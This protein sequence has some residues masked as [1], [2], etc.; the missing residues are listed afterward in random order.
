MRRNRSLL[1]ISIAL[2][3]LRDPGL[4]FHGDALWHVYSAIARNLFDYKRRG[5]C[6]D[7]DEIV[8]M[9]VIGLQCRRAPRAEP[10]LMSRDCLRIMTKHAQGW[11]SAPRCCCFTMRALILYL[12]LRLVVR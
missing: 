8:P 3:Q 2:L 11:P 5:A 7:T 6:F 4:S 10:T 9:K 12:I 1:Y